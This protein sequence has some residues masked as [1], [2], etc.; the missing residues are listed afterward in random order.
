[1]S[2]VGKILVVVQLVLSVLFMSFAAAVNSAHVNW[3]KETIKAQD[4][5]KKVQAAIRSSPRA[6][7]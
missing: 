6:A 3:R 1:M 7:M 4:Q 5:V 2:F